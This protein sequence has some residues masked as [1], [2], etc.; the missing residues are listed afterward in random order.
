MVDPSPNWSPTALQLWNSDETFAQIMTDGVNG[1]TLVDPVHC[2]ML[3]QLLLH[4]QRLDGQVLEV[5][6]YRG[7]TA[8]L[9]IRAMSKDKIFFGCD[10]FEGL[11]PPDRSVDPDHETGQFAADYQEVWN[12][13]KRATDKEA[14]QPTIVLT[15]GVFP[16]VAADSIG[17]N[18]FCFAHVDVDLYRSV[19]DTVKWLYPRMVPGGVIVFDDY[20]F[21]QCN[22]AKVAVDKFFQDKPESVIYLP[23]GQAM[24]IR[25]G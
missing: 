23:T 6:V 8:F 20:G 19:Y 9:L 7:G 24:V 11:P 1:R 16:G 25:N 22:G 21:P 14:L 12:H 18:L 4:S 10:T 17:N 15:K 5:G 13:L 2:Y 3:Y